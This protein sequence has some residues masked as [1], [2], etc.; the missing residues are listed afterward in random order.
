MHSQRVPAASCTNLPLFGEQNF[1]CCH[2]LPPG[3]RMVKLIFMGIKSDT[4]QRHREGHS[5]FRRQPIHDLTRHFCPK[6]CERMAWTGQ[7]RNH[8]RM[9]SSVHTRDAAR[10]GT[11]ATCCMIATRSTPF[12]S[13]RS[14]S[15]VKTFPLPAHSPNLNC[16]ALG[17]IAE[18]GMSVQGGSFW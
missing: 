15:Q 18:G 6:R 12:R 4:W 5:H 17:E 14:S 7:N 11:V 2:Y 8:W 16:G 9:R 10:F 13:G 1:N 3:H